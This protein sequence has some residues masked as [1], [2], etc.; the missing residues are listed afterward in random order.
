MNARFT[1]TLGTLGALA[2]SSAFAE[3][4]AELATHATPAMRVSAQV[5]VLPFGSAKTSGGQVTPSST[6]TAVAYGI[7]GGFEY[8]VT[9]YLSVGAAPRLVLNVTPKDASSMDKAE[10]E[11][12]LR[13]VVRGHYPISPGLEVFG[14]VMPG[15]SIVLS[16]TDGVDSSKGFGIGGAIG[17]TYD[18]SPAVFLSGEV[19]YQRAFTST[20]V[21]VLSQSFNADL[22]V[23]YAHVALGAGT[24]F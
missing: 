2:S 16:S 4:G 1:F 19:G 23:S 3:E 14:A 22:D 8:A 13:A 12:D 7:T 6:D 21:K 24:R 18:L 11:L 20:T 10:K 5:E 9:R 15:Y 17:A